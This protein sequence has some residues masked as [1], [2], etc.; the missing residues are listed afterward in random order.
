MNRLRFLKDSTIKINYDNEDLIITYYYNHNF[1][2]NNILDART[3]TNLGC[4]ITNKAVFSTL[5]IAYMSKL[6]HYI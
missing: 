4:P 3:I 6:R 2:E 5:H 1:I